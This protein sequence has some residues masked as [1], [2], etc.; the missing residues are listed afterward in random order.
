ML[1]YN[2]ILTNLFFFEKFLLV[3]LL[4]PKGINQKD[5]AGQPDL[6]RKSLFNYFRPAE[7][8]RHFH[9]IQRAVYLSDLIACQNNIRGCK[10]FL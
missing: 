6:F 10:V 1:F 3:Y 5:R 9:I 8:G 4:L 2:Y 7:N